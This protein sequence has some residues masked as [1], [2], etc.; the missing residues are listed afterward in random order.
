MPA[1]RLSSSAELPG[2][3]YTFA[4]V[5]RDRYVHWSN[6][7][8]F[9]DNHQFSRIL[10]QDWYDIF[11]ILFQDGVIKIFSGM[12]ISIVFLDDRYPGPYPLPSPVATYEI[13]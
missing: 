1:N 13:N 8:Y 9:H 10:F 4:S 2:Q 7:D 11:R 6:L 3:D 12:H 5:F